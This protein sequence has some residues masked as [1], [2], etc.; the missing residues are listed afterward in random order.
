MLA[1]KLIEQKQ[2]IP[3]DI[4]LSNNV[5]EYIREKKLLKIVSEEVFGK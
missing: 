3:K 5:Y 2:D 4:F 1:I